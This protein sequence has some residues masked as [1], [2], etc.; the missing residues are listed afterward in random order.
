[1]FIKILLTINSTTFKYVATRQRDV[2]TFLTIIIREEDL[3]KSGYFI[4]IVV[5]ILGMIL[6]CD[7]K[8]NLD[9]MI[10]KSFIAVDSLM[11]E[12]ISGDCIIQANQIDS[13]NIKLAHNYEPGG[14]F[15]P[16]FIQEGKKLV[17]REKFQGPSSGSSVWT[18]NLPR[19]TVINVSSVSG[20]L[21][22]AENLF[23]LVSNTISGTITVSNSEGS[24]FLET[25]SGEIK[26]SN[27][28]GEFTIK[29]ISGDLDFKNIEVRKRSMWSSVSGDNSISLA[30][31]SENDII[32]GSI[33]GNS[34]LN[35]QGNPIS[36]YFEFVAEVEK[37]TIQSPI[38]FTTESTFQKEEKTYDKK[39][40]Q[41]VKETPK[42]TIS[43]ISG[44]AELR[45]M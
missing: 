19:K 17:I 11:I 39:S 36:G 33:S 34:L 15:Q 1:M 31:E 27:V 38:P 40:F 22:I 7:Q 35:Y 30:K 16:E 10:H 26:G 14:T 9:Q 4:V 18:F 21:E 43:T 8:K 37:G 28:S 29:S 42:I 5:A 6:S 45:K 2:G 24:F 25:V 41:L 23:E 20:N 12:T 3:M 32:I 13:I 44:V